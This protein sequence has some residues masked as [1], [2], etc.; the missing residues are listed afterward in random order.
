MD[1]LVGLIMVLDHA[2]AIPPHFQNNLLSHQQPLFHRKMLTR[3]K[4]D[5]EVA[6]RLSG[7]P[8][9]PRYCLKFSPKFG[10]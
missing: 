4:R 6:D 5:R 8:A 3:S 7:V 10:D 2:I 1:M 9:D